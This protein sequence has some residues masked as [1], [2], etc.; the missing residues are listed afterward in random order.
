MPLYWLVIAGEHWTSVQF[1]PVWKS[2]WQWWTAAAS[3][4]SLRA[5]FNRNRKNDFVEQ[6][7]MTAGGGE[8][9][10]SVQ[11]GAWK[12]WKQA[13][14]SLRSVP[15]R[16]W[17]YIGPVVVGNVDDN[18]VRSYRLHA[19]ETQQLVDAT[20]MCCLGGVARGSRQPMTGRLATHPS[21]TM[22][23]RLIPI[24]MC[25]NILY[26]FAGCS[27]RPVSPAAVIGGVRSVNRLFTNHALQWLKW[28]TRHSF[29]VC[30]LSI[31]T[32]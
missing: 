6:S 20:R 9:F 2:D 16:R 12:Y 10:V 17:W 27:D 5:C 4:V 24:A 22:V 32:K 11:T 13:A 18:S 30:A 28:S 25:A 1:S 26:P 23:K 19:S 21:N 29:C 14:T 3:S 7:V 8:A 15:A 31:S